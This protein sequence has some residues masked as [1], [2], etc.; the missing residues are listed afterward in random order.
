MPRRR[1]KIVGEIVH[2]CSNPQVVNAALASIRFAISDDFVMRLSTEA[3]RRGLAPDIYAARLVR[4][5]GASA[6]H[7]TW[8][9]AESMARG[10][11]QP[12]LSGLLSILDLGLRNE[13]TASAAARRVLGDRRLSS[14]GAGAASHA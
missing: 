2:T 11:D 13:A 3:G 8:A 12:I 14:A 7:E 6:D 1:S 4:G 10:K 5:F 9:W